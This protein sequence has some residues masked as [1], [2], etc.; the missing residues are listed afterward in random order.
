MYPRLVVAI[1][2][3]V[4]ETAMECYANADPPVSYPEVL[5]RGFA[6]VAAGLLER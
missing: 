6:E 1:A 2:R 3:A 5:R 4:G